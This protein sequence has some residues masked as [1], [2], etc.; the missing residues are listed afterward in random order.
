MPIFD[1]VPE[2]FPPVIEPVGWLGDVPAF[3]WAEGDAVVAWTPPPRCKFIVGDYMLSFVAGDEELMVHVMRRE[4]SPKATARAQIEEESLKD[5][6]WMHMLT[7]KSVPGADSIVTPLHDEVKWVAAEH[8]ELHVDW[9]GT[10]TENGKTSF[11]GKPSVTVIAREDEKGALG[12]SVSLQDREASPR[13]RT[14]A[15]MRAELARIFTERSAAPA[16]DQVA[17][18]TTDVG[19]A[20][21]DRRRRRSSIRGWVGYRNDWPP[22]DYENDDAYSRATEVVV[23]PPRRRT[24]IDLRGERA[25]LIDRLDRGSGNLPKSRDVSVENHGHRL[26]SC[27]EVERENYELPPEFEDDPDDPEHRDPPEIRW[28]Q[29]MR[30]GYIAVG[31]DHVVSVR[32]TVGAQ[33]ADRLEQAWADALGRLYVTRNGDSAAEQP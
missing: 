2:C 24:E 11:H 10:F 29:I 14:T 31:A 6:L 8:D 21:Y 5:R 28:G 15:E 30:C 25:H 33:I 22:E 26:F 32:V 23:V 4:H 12:V 7:E 1:R 27:F 18:W 3:A 13:R 16:P 19:F 9:W 20:V 17:C